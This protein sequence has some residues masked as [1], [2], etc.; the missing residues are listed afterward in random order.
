MSRWMLL[1]LFVAAGVLLG[2]AGLHPLLAGAGWL[3]I[4]LL[5][6]ALRSPGAASLRAMGAVV[7]MFI[8]NA[9]MPTSTPLAVRAYFPDYGLLRCAGLSLAI[10]A[11]AALAPSVVFGGAVLLGDRLRRCRQAPHLALPAALW[12][13]PLWL[14]G[15]LG[16]R[17]FMPTSFDWMYTQWQVQSVLRCVAAL[18]YHPT[19][20]LCVSAAAALG[21]ALHLRRGIA[22]MPAAA[23]LLAAL[24]LP[25]LPRT[26][27]A[28]FAGIGLVH[29][30]SMEA[31]LDAVPPGLSLLVWP[32]GS[33][34][35]E[36]KISEARAPGRQ[37]PLPIATAADAGPSHLY[38]IHTRLQR[39]FQQ[40]SV[41]AQDPTGR[42]LGMRAKQVL[43]PLAER[44]F[45][46]TR[47]TPPGYFL[48]GE[49]PPLLVV[50]DRSIIPLVC[51]EV[52]ERGLFAEGKRR[53]GQMA[54]VLSSDRAFA[55]LPSSHRLTL[56]MLVMRAVE[57]GVPALRASRAGYAAFVGADGTVLARSELGTTGVL[58]LDGR[59][60]ASDYD[61]AGRRVRITR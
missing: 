47:K 2:T 59:G 19:L 60:T 5:A 30:A 42:V 27:P 21:D 48:P 44:P 25:A 18:G 56:G 15:E 53:G 13:P 24:M 23:Y 38:G 29:L 31:R 6:L 17:L 7:A 8:A 45:L 11:V 9:M 12:L 37:L 46:P 33:V 14:L 54:A 28:Q 35:G 61:D 32:E 39:G 41:L 34:G 10:W 49:A 52:V 55:S 16:R 4:A 22:L 43:V 36:P 57:Y 3:G 1:V 26:D 58:T 40:N 50:D 20:I 51:I